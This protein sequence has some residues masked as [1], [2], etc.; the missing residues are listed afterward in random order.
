MKG[1][2]FEDNLRPLP[3]VKHDALEKRPFH[4]VERREERGVRNRRGKQPTCSK[5]R[6]VAVYGNE[7]RCIA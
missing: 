4:Q 5:K 2:R 3:L 6:D 7:H 1:K